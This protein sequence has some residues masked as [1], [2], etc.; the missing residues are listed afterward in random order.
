M[1]TNIVWATDGS[2]HAERA[3]HYAADIAQRD[4]AKLHVVRVVQK[5]PPRK[6]A[7]E[8]N[9]LLAET[10]SRTRWRARH[11]R[12]PPNEM[13]VEVE[14]QHPRAALTNLHERSRHV[15]GL[16]EHGEPAIWLQQHPQARAHDTVIVSQNDGDPACQCRM[17]VLQ[18]GCEDEVPLS[19]DG[20]DM[21]PTTLCRRP[22]ARIGL[23]TR[24]DRWRP[25]MFPH[26]RAGIHRAPQPPTV[27][28]TVRPPA[29]PSFSRAP[30][31]RAPAH[32]PPVPPAS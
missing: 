4:G 6:L 23:A 26:P 16:I 3:L 21:W 15:T 20:N 19:M 10:T 25:L 1:F 9:T 7:G 5:L 29:S 27:P 18:R 17:N 32:T 28:G 14:H 24:S 30:S 13:S 8:L 2:E 12:S 22:L 31:G 11:A